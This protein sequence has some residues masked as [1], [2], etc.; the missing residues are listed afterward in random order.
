LTEGERRLAAIMFTDMVGYTALGQRNESLSLALVEKQRKVIRP[1][2]VR[3]NGR[4]VKTIGDAFLVEFPNALDAVRCA[5]DIQRA[6]REFNISMPPEQRLHLRIGV[7][8]GD[9]VESSGDIF[10]DAVNV[11]SRIEPLAED[12]GVCL[13]QE[14]YNH[15]RNKFELPVSKV[16]PKTLKNVAEP[17]EVYKVVMPWE[18]EHSEPTPQL[19]PKRVAVLPFVSMSPDPNDEYFADGLTDELITKMSLLKGLEVIARTSVMNYKKKE[20]NVSQIGK[21]LNVGTLLEGSVRKAGNRIRVSAQ[22]IN[23]STEAHLWAENYDKVLDDIFEVQSSVAENVA[24]ALKLKLLDNAKERIERRPRNPEAYVEYLK[25]LFFTHKSGEESAR[26]AIRHFERALELEPNYPEALALAGGAYG[27]LGLMGYAPLEEMYAK[28][29]EMN[30]KALELDDTIPEAHYI[31]AL[32]AYYADGNWAK[33]EAEYKRAIELNPNYVDAVDDYAVFL[34]CLGRNDESMLEIEKCLKL[35]PLKAA[36]YITAGAIY[37]H[38]RRFSEALELFH[39][40]LELDPDSAAGHTNLGIAYILMG[41]TED[42]VRELEKAMSMRGTLPKGNLGYA[43]AVAG[44][45]EDALRLL[46]EIKAEPHVGQRSYALACIYAAL[47]EKAKALDWLEKA[48]E[49]RA[50]FV[51]PML[52]FEPALASLREEQRFKELV[53]KLGLDGYQRS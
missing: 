23:A 33:A 4:E 12:G 39:K 26:K 50:I 27:G 5:Y 44:R 30:S 20:K 14:V 31:M 22:L 25:G 18:K 53:K 15:V 34:D 46:E 36:S 19:D 43:Y 16:G 42:G 38:A 48:Y 32:W 49:E 9:V 10:G 13:T 52:P 45:R 11:A 2:L 37:G 40:A 41:R 3:H 51:W 24:N 21:E 7:H 17:V 29:K 8:D 1:I 28:C 6:V 47:G 35:D